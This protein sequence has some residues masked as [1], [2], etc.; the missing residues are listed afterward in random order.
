MMEGGGGG[1]N[2]SVCGYGAVLP[3][4]QAWKNFKKTFGR[5]LQR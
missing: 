4:K 5:E 2:P 3:K 1:V